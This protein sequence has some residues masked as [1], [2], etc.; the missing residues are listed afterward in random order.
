MTNKILLGI[1]DFAKSLPLIGNI[2]TAVQGE[3]AQAKAAGES[4]FQVVL[5]DA[6]VAV[7]LIPNA[8]AQGV[9]A[10]AIDITEEVAA[11]VNAFKSAQAKVSAAAP[12][13]PASAT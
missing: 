13:A 10:I 4:T 5:S 3:T 7:Q 9:G 2:V 11:I 8:V 12:A 6:S 1:E